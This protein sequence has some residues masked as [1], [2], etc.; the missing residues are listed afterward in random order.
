MNTPYNAGRRAAERGFSLDDNPYQDE[1]SASEWE[2]G[3]Y[4][5]QPR[6]K[7]RKGV[8]EWA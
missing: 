1:Q 8:R 5:Y 7:I 6:Q 4:S 2:D 3:F